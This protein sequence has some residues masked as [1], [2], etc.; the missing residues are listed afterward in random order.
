MT[1]R[2]SHRWGASCLTFSSHL[3]RVFTIIVNIHCTL[4]YPMWQ[5]LCQTKHNCV[6]LCLPTDLQYCYLLGIQPF[7]EFYCTTF[8][9]MYS[10]PFTFTLTPPTRCCR[11][12]QMKNHRFPHGKTFCHGH[13][14]SRWQAWYSNPTHLPLLPLRFLSSQWLPLAPSVSEHLW[15]HRAFFFISF[16]GD[17]SHSGQRLPCHWLGRCKLV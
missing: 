9:T 3:S 2:A 17:L 14:A 13:T 5:A 12:F 4:Q 8:L 6:V 16:S 1:C 11:P 10:A 7:T 15:I